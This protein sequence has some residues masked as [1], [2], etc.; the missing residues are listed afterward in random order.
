M[1]YFVPL[2]LILLC[3]S[4]EPQANHVV[5]LLMATV[6]TYVIYELGYIENDTVTIRREV[7]PTLR[8][9]DLEQEYIADYWLVIILVRLVVA[10]A[11]FNYLSSSPGTLLYLGSLLCLALVFPLYN[12]RRS[13]VNAALHPVL[14]TARYCGPLLLLMPDLVVF[15]YALLMFPILNGLERGAEHRYQI[16]LLQGVSLANGNSGRWA[17]YLLVLLGW[18]GVCA[19]SDLGWLTAIPLL[20][21]LLY[22]LIAPWI[23]KRVGEH[24][25]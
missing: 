7:E 5:Q 17:Y 24:Q 13:S 21:M 22:R 3:F 18:L 10:V 1:I 9:D 12:R 14:V 20:Y 11:L 15:I 25:I 19:F 6:C 8:L 2:I 16:R 23:I 4:P